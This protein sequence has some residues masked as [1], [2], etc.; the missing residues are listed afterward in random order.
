ME[1]RRAHPNLLAGLW[2]AM[3]V[4]LSK[5]SSTKGSRRP[6]ALLHDADVRHRFPVD[7]VRCRSPTL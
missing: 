7:A 1:R 4:A 6:H 3:S 5:A 2:E